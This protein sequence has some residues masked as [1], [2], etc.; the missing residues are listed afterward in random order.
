MNVCVIVGLLLNITGTLLAGR[1]LQLDWQAHGQGR[2]LLPWLVQSLGWVR[3]HVL[4]RR[5]TIHAV[6]GS[7]ASVSSVGEVSVWMTPA[8]PAETDPVDAQIAYLRRAVDALREQVAAHRNET[9]AMVDRVAQSVAEA[10]KDAQ[11]AV[12]RVE[13]MA[14]DIAVGTVKLQM[15]GLFLI[16]SGTIIGAL[17]A[18]LGRL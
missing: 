10:R 13:E 4:R 7:I 18:L 15:L 1:A 11:T 6:L 17:P 2:P 16:G 3:V 9:N 12:S 8:V 14:R 5:G